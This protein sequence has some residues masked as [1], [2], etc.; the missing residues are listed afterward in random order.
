MNRLWRGLFWL[1]IIN[2][3]AWLLAYYVYLLHL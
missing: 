2:P 1:V 3:A